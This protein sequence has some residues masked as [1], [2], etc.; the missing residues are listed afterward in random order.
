M[1]RIKRK[2]LLKPWKRRLAIRFTRGVAFSATLI[3]V[4]LIGLGFAYTWVVSKNTKIVESKIDTST[5]KGTTIK[6]ASPS[7]DAPVGVSIQSFTPR[8]TPGSEVSIAVRTLEGS[9]CK[10]KVVNE[11]NELIS[12]AGLVDQAANGYGMASWDWD[13]P[14]SGAIGEW[15]VDVT[16]YRNGKSGFARG[17]LEIVGQLN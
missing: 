6:R 15:N 13:V 2:G 11:K 10:I 5:S 4:A 8:V 17:Y 12:S 1:L 16:C 7:P 9:N 14:T 3:A